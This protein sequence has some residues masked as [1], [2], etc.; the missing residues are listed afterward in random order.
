MDAD[1][2]IVGQMSSQNL[3]YKNGK[4]TFAGKNILSL[5]RRHGSPCYFY[6]LKQMRSRTLQLKDAFGNSADIHYAMKANHCVGVLKTLKSA[7]TGVDTVSGGEIKWALGC[8]FRPSQIIFSGVGKSAEEIEFAVRKKIKIL[9]VESP[10]E[11]ERVGQISK[12]LKMP[13]SVGF[14][15]NPHVSPKTHPYISTGFRENKFGMGDEFLPQVRRILKNYSKFLNMEGVSLHIGSQIKDLGVFFDAV[16]KTRPV[17]EAFRELGHQMRF[18]DV[19]GG[20]GIDYHD[21][22]KPAPSLKKYSDG[23]Q[24]ELL[25][26]DTKILLEPGRWLVGPCG[27][28]VAQVEYIKTTR[29]KRFVILNSGMNHLIRPA[30]YQAEHRILSVKKGKDLPIRTDIV[31]PICES[32]DF[33]GLNRRLPKLASGDFVAIGEAGAYGFTM[34][35]EYNL[36]RP[37]KEIC[38]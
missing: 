19:G 25:G 2:G 34:A 32:S 24:R 22:R 1:A 28:L 16:R 10:A 17:Y 29:D 23:I 27:I 15:Y 36:H 31:G 5:A 9:N 26:L 4:L 13:I 37:P 20:L 12:R 21:E 30:L 35:S 38:L 14:R 33:L 11:L 8:G 3:S 18:F 7:G 6:D